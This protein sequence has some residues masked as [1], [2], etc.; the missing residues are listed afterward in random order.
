MIEVRMLTKRRGAQLPPYAVDHLTFDALPGRVTGLLG[1]P[2]AGKSTVLHAVMGLVEPDSGVALVNGRPFRALRAPAAEIGALLFPRAFH[3]AATVA[4]HLRARARA[5]GLPAGRVDA[6]LQQSGLAP[7]AD[8]P[9]HSL[10]AG[11]AHRLGLAS[12][13]L[14]FSVRKRS[15]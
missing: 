4:G 7:L 10:T 8:R 1:P 15:A 2:G 6:V 12:A 5:D 13:L 11:L 3:P 14:W 9:T